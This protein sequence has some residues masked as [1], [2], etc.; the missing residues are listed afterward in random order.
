[1]KYRTHKKK[2]RKWAQ[3]L[4]GKDRSGAVDAVEPE[5]SKTGGRERGPKKG[6]WGFTIDD[7]HCATMQ[8]GTTRAAVLGK[9]I[10]FPQRRKGWGGEKEAGYMKR[11]VSQT[12][13]KAQVQ[14]HENTAKS[15]RQSIIRKTPCASDCREGTEFGKGGGTNYSGGGAG[16]FY[17]PD[18]YKGA[19]LGLS[20]KKLGPGKKCVRHHETK[21]GRVCLNLAPEKMRLLPYGGEKDCEWPL[22]IPEVSRGLNVMEGAWEQG[23]VTKEWASLRK[24]CGEGKTPWQ[25]KSICTANFVETGFEQKCNKNRLRGEVSNLWKKVPR[26]QQL[27]F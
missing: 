15:H 5:Q 27:C 4:G 19:L 22:T 10:R 11:V 20:E 24:T 26:M 17:L 7:L 2:R 3:T 6:G 18:K 21:L 13:K 14:I 16:D 12:P 25:S 8:A 9:D 1:V 23:I